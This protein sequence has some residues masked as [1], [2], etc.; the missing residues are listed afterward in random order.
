MKELLGKRPEL[1]IINTLAL[2][3]VGVGLPVVVTQ[4]ISGNEMSPAPQCIHVPNRERYNHG[5]YLP[6]SFEKNN[7]I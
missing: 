4:P 1:K 7:T 6:S 3:F 5:F 2:L